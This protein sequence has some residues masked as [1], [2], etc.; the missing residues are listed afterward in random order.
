MF[1]HA[2]GVDHDALFTSSAKMKI[3]VAKVEDQLWGFMATAAA[4]RGHRVILI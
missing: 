2:R 4:A 3:S 1:A